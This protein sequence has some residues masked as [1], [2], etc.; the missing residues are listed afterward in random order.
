[1]DRR[2]CCNRADRWRDPGARVLSAVRPAPLRADGQGDSRC[3]YGRAASSRG[4]EP[5]ILAAA[6]HITGPHIDWGGLSPLVALTTGALLVLLIGLLPGA[7]A[8]QHV[9]PILTLLTLG[10][11]IG[12]EIGQF[13]HGKSVVSGALAIDDLALV[14]DMI[15]A[16]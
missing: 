4:G 6:Q 15:F 11:S 1:M 7:V 14:L 9:V 13:K 16:V 8:R 10:A 12:F 5:V 3:G 2:P